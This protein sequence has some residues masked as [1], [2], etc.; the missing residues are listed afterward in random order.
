MPSWQ[1]IG[2]MNGTYRLS[3][4]GQANF[5]GKEVHAESRLSR[6]LDG[7]LTPVQYEESEKE[8]L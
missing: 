7:K 5:A 1:G 4:T 2:N 6:L 8:H 3:F